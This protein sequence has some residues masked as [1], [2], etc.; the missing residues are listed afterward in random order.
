PFSDLWNGPASDHNY[1]NFFPVIAD[2]YVED[3]SPL[4]ERI[5]AIDASE[6][7]RCELCAEEYLSRNG[8]RL[9]AGSPFRSFLPV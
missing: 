4:R 8:G 6:W 5:E 1:A 7:R 3:P 2:F 9:R